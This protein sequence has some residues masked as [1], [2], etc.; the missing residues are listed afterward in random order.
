MSA[1][2]RVE[3]LRLELS[4]S[5]TVEELERRLLAAAP[6]FHAALRRRTLIGRRH[7]LGLRVVSLEMPYQ[8]LAGVTGAETLVALKAGGNPIRRRQTLAHECAHGLLRDVD[9]GRLELSREAEDK[10]CSRFARKALM[11]PRLVH[12]FLAAEGFPGDVDALRA[13][14][15]RFQVGLR[16]AIAALNEYG[17]A[18]GPVVLIAATYRGH[19]KRPGERAFRVDAAASSPTVFAPRD[20]RLASMGLWEAAEWGRHAPFGAS[21]D[22]VAPHALFLARL[23]TKR[24]WHGKARWSARAVSAAAGHGSTEAR[25]LVMTID[26]SELSHLATDPTRKPSLFRV[27]RPHP[28]Q[29]SLAS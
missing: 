4:A 24:C 8:G 18:A 9:R 26:A 13:F 21:R 7:D 16:P 22:G 27:R 10:L 11:P 5:E 20:R 17:T 3:A 6:R 25:S 23:P 12:G 15:S 28:E 1:S 29:P 14:C 2:Q 19:E